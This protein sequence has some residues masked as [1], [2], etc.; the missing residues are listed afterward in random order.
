MVLVGEQSIA[1][2]PF[3][4]ISSDKENEYFSDGVTEEIINA[5]TKVEGLN[6]IA[7]SSSFTF[8][9]QN[10]DPKKVGDQ[11]GVA[12]ILE[13]SVR[14]A[15][16]KVR[17]AAQLIKVSDS[18]HVFSEVYDQE[19]KDIFEVQD[20]IA[21]RIV[22]KFKENIGTPESRKKLISSSTKNIEAYE[23]YLKGRYNLSKGSLEA[24]KAAIQ[25][26]EA[27]LLKDKNFVL[28]VT[29][30]AACYTFLGGSGLMNANQAFEKAKEYANKSNLIDDSVADTHLALAKSFFWCDWNFEKT[31]SSIR[32]AIR[33]APGTSS[34]HGF[35]SIYLLATGNL[36][37]ALIEA[38]L[39][40]RLDPLS[41]SSRF[42]LG[43]LYY[44][45]ESYIE[46][47][48]IFNEILSENSFHTQANIFKAWCHLF[49]GELDSAI[50]I[51]S[52]IPISSEDSITFYGGLAFAYFKKKQHDKILECLRR[53]NSEVEK[54][55]QYWLNYNYTLIFRAL[56][57]T[58]KMFENLEKCLEEKITPLVFINVDPVWNDFRNDPH[59]IELI[60]KAFVPG[61]EDRM[62]SIKTDT[63]EEL[64]INLNELVFI[65]A[66]ENYSR[67][68][69]TEG[70]QVK[71][72]L[73][74]VTLKNIEGQ[75]VDDNI[76]RCHRSFIINTKIEFTILGNSNG[77]RL[78]S[79]LISDT[80]PISRS[81]GKE[82]VDKIKK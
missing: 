39:A 42:H 8:K 54:G 16:H 78:E 47:I 43:E 80:I 66:Q 24:T 12:Y 23:L 67:V 28:P 21:N 19:L 29:G 27:A 6:V 75:V 15:G 32:K 61:K 30:L 64:L 10:T 5:L 41:L 44:R 1:V 81:L 22:Q 72:K 51:F 68:V 69:W 49:L 71:E 48:N 34:I 3:R 45:S 38:K 58:G 70:D 65:E 77:Y 82:I 18:F 14:R 46:A 25:Y 59:F 26:F 79:E 2:L 57:E 40:A 13:G 31:G 52:Q 17:V 74:R 11:L 35:N 20:D 53:F 62:A 9:D 63:K 56:G 7:R 36:D 50:S 60:E 76:V 55:N 4:N 33:L 37:E 73:L